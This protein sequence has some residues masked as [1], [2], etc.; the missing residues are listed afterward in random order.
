MK[1]GPVI[2]FGGGRVIRTDGRRKV[3]ESERLTGLGTRR[4]RNTLVRKN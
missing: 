1:D 4:E 3:K 2:E